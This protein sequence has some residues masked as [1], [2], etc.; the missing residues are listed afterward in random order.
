EWQNPARLMRAL[1]FKRSTGE[2]I[3][4]FRKGER[5]KRPFEII[6]IALDVE[7]KVLY[8]RINRR[9]DAMMEAGLMDEV[10]RLY[11]YRA[12]K[13][14]QTVGYQ[15]F[16]EYEPFPPEGDDLNAATDKVKQH[17]RNYAKRQIT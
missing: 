12:L 2:S 13:N 16:Y 6:K 10:I 15:E 5:K 11:P 7:R 4:T 14:L 3:T 8:D 1:A 17:T 9:V